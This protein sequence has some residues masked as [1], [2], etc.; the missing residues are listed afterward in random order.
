[1]SVV[2]KVGGV[3]AG[4]ATKKIAD[5]IID[6]EGEDKS[7][8]KSAGTT[9]AGVAVGRMVDDALDGDN[10]KE[11]KE[12]EGK[13]IG[14]AVKIGGAVAAAAAV[15]AAHDTKEIK[16]MMKDDQKKGKANPFAGTA[17]Q[18]KNDKVKKPESSF[19]QL[20]QQV[21]QNIQSDINGKGL[22]QM[23]TE[24]EQEMFV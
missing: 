22:N 21:Q 16:E 7:F 15:K 2:S 5:D 18:K 10:D 14:T 6:N 20:T 11:E 4:I 19:E 3:A 23:G 8:L 1:M 17:F 13:G 12:K 24:Q 9:V